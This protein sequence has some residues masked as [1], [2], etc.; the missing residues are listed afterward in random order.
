MEPQDVLRELPLWTRLERDELLS[1]ARSLGVRVEL[2]VT[3]APVDE[4]WCRIEARNAEPP[5]DREP[6]TRAR[7]DRWVEQFERPGPEEAALFDG[8]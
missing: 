6:I 4:L 3:D 7:L 5:W 8:P 1:R 2:H